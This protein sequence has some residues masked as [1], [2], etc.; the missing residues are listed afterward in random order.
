MINLGFVLANLALVAFI[1]WPQGTALGNAP[2]LEREQLCIPPLLEG[3]LQ[4]SSPG[5]RPKPKREE[6]QSAVGVFRRLPTQDKVVALTFDDGPQGTKKLLRVLA[7]KQVPATFFLLGDI[8]Q[9]RPDSVQAIVDAGC[10]IGNHTWSHP[11]LTDL[12]EEEVCWQITASQQVFEA[13]KVES[14]PLVRPP[15]GMWDEGV[16]EVCASLGYGM[17]L[18]DVDTRDWECSEASVVLERALDGL[19]PGC[20]ILFH[21]GKAVTR[22]I[23]PEFIDEARSR[24]YRFVLVSEYLN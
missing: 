6:P 22:E 20:V 3:V 18:W 8:A 9:G 2:Q 5:V 15:Y 11:R 16:A 24:G 13:L 17:L 21:E 7:E 4:V 14:L 1:L 12:T 19:K 10:E 23:L